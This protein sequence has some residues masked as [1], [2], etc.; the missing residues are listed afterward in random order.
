MKCPSCGAPYDKRA[1]VSM[2]D[3]IGD[4]VSMT[5]HQFITNFPRRCTSKVDVRLDKILTGDE[6]YIYLHSH[7]SITNVRIDV[8]EPKPKS[9][10]EID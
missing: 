2:T 7:R 4:A 8:T 5:F 6:Y 10:L 9:L 3:S 1:K